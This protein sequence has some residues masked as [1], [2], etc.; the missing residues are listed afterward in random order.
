MKKHTGLSEQSLVPCRPAAT[1]RPRRQAE[2]ALRES[3]E[4]ERSS[5]SCES[6]A[7]VFTCS[8][9]SAVPC[10]PWLSLRSGTALSS[11]SNLYITGDRTRKILYTTK[12]SFQLVP[13]TMAQGSPAT[14][15][16]LASLP[17]ENRLAIWE[18][19]FKDLSS[20]LPTN[21][22]YRYNSD[23]WRY[24]AQD[25]TIQGLRIILRP[26]IPLLS[27]SKSNPRR[28]LRSSFQEHHAAIESSANVA[29]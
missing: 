26:Y 24:T 27:I 18:H 29:C 10:I 9:Y 19:Y 22:S 17:C 2:R 7:Q 21:D 11:T 16:G 14:L 25:P 8:P 5:H 4:T 28:D 23:T 13:E 3:L 12:S 20:L 6:I 1:Q 15:K